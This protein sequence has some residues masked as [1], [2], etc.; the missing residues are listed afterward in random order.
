MHVEKIEVSENE[1]LTPEETTDVVKK[2]ENSNLTSSVVKELI[3]R[4][5]ELCVEKGY[6][7]S[8]AYLLEQEVNKGVLKI[9]IQEGK[10]GKIRIMGNRWTKKSHILS[11]LDMHEGEYFNMKKLANNIMNYNHYNDGVILKADLNPGE[12]ENTTDIDITVEEQP[13]YHLIGIADNSGRDAVGR[14]R[15]GLLAGHDSLFGLRDKLSACIYANRH[16]KT[17]FIDYN[18][19]VNKYDGRVGGYTFSRICPIDLLIVYSP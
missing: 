5:D 12:K 14:N 16:S 3:G 18:I 10:V 9:S 8:F 1:I 6:I 17:P 13:P 7:T 4:L 2:Y 15:A 19:P 11:R